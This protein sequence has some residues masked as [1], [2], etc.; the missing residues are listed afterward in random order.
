VLSLTTPVICF[1]AKMNKVLNRNNKTAIFFMLKLVLVKKINSGL[2]NIE[3]KVNLFNK[4]LIKSLIFFKKSSKKTY[5]VIF[6]L[7]TRY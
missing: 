5:I 6:C 4:I 3:I 2:L 1:C 7:V